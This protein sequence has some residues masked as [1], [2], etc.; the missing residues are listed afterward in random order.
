MPPTTA[1]IWML[2]STRHGVSLS[3]LRSLEA[4]QIP[5]CVHVCMCACAYVDDCSY[6]T[7]LPRAPH[8][9]LTDTCEFSIRGVLSVCLQIT[10]TRPLETAPNQMCCTTTSTCENHVC[11][12]R[13][14]RPTTPV[15]TT[16]VTTTG[17]TCFLCNSLVRCPAHSEGDTGAVNE[18]RLPRR[19][20]GESGTTSTAAA[21]A[22]AAVPRQ[23]RNYQCGCSWV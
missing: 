15:A 16:T 4:R 21:A 8:L 17:I 11:E 3:R 5:Q 9:V 6:H 14:K 18:H 7:P 22:A 23:P 1:I 2:P 10:S 13:S 19:G 12:A 20:S